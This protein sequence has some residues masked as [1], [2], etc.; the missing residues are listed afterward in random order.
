MNPNEQYLKV[1]KFDEQYEHVFL[2]ERKSNELDPAV[3]TCLPGQVLTGPNFENL[4]KMLL[5]KVREN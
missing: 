2:G 5:K 3:R 4:Q 1:M